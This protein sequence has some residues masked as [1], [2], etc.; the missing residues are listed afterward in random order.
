MKSKREFGGVKKRINPD[1]G[2]ST[3]RRDLL[4]ERQEGTP[5]SKRMGLTIQKKG[6]NKMV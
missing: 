3:M 4:S 6:E 1:K 5:K 2:E